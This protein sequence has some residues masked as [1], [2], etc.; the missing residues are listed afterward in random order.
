MQETKYTAAEIA[1]LPWHNLEWR[2]DH[3]YRIVDEQGKS[4][5]FVLNDEQRDLLRH[6]HTRNLILKA[7]QLGFSTLMQVLEFDQAL[8]CANHTGVV[9]ADTIPNAGKLFGKIEHALKHLDPIIADA[10]P[11]RSSTSKTIIEFENGSSVSVSTSSRGG[12]VQFLH[13]SELGKIARKWPE[14]AQEIVTGAFESVPSDGVIVVES[15]AEG[16]F[17]EYWDLVE[18]ALKR[19]REGAPE[20][21][22]D[23]RLHFYAWFRKPA[24]TLP[25]PEN[26]IF[27]PEDHKYF[28]ELE[29]KEGIRLTEGQ[30]AWYVK[31]KETLGRK[32][33][34]EYPS[35]P[36]EAFEVAIE[37]AIFGEEMARVRELGRI[38]DVPIDPNHPV[39]TF[40]DLGTGDKTAIWLLQQ[41]GFQ[42][43]WVGYRADSH[44]SLRYWWFEYLEPLRQEW[45]FR[46]GRHFL[47]HDA[48]NNMQGEA[49]TTKRQILEKLGMERVE[50]VPRIADKA[51]AI[52]LMR[53][54]LPADNW[55]DKTQCADG[56]LS[57]DGYQYEWNDKL[58]RWSNDPLHNWASDGV[59]AWMQYAQGYT[60]Y[61]VDRQRNGIH[62]L[63]NGQ[64]GWR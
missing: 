20:T 30:R 7:R 5:P 60:P 9:I 12:T 62:A 8:F 48:D 47:P 3:L 57:I 41:I 31:K 39:S 35:T 44:R 4:I 32:I 17:G 24:Y 2:L 37:G 52:D 1:A 26:V 27:R 63:I 14:R 15:T 22:L 49:I 50:V 21:S 19:K 10:H 13:V 11:V 28:R 40:W 25:D 55:F 53:Q 29:A 18:P 64:R 45:K 36:E 51:L 33:K 61:S 43:R 54:K 6:L 23:W 58:G 34:Q 56:L 38:T 16:A 59:D 42:K 46:W